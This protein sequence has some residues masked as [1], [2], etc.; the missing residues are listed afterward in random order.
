MTASLLKVEINHEEDYMELKLHMC[1]GAD[2]IVTLRFEGCIEY[3]CDGFDENN[4]IYLYWGYFYR[5]EHRVYLSLDAFGEV[6][7]DNM[8]VI[9]IDPA[10]EEV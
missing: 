1:N 6:S 10:T 4:C 7:A 8:R 2:D 5:L 9:S 3:E